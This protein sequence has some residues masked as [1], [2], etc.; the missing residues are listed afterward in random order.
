MV[1][2]VTVLVTMVKVVEVFPPGMVTL[3]GTRATDGLLLLRVTASPLA[4][5]G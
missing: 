1:D 5:A 2:V 4:H 3:A